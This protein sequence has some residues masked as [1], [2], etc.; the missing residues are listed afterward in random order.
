MLKHL[1][2]YLSYGA[3]E[4]RR[5]RRLNGCGAT[6]AVATARTRA[7][8][9]LLGGVARRGRRPHPERRRRRDTVSIALLPVV[10][11]DVEPNDYLEYYNSLARAAI[12][13]AITAARGAGADSVRVHHLLLGVMR[14]D[15]DLEIL[16]RSLGVSLD[17]ATAWASADAQEEPGTSWPPYTETAADVL[18]VACLQPLGR[19]GRVSLAEAVSGGWLV[20]VP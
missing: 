20:H 5:R 6:A 17:D 11:S 16:L 14:V 4:P 15:K 19:L 2:A 12:D 7:A 18:G 13:V 10:S 9:R 1:T 8:A 3:A